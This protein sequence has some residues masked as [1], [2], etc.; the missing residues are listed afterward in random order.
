[1]NI[2]EVLRRQAADRG[3]APALID[4]HRGQDR[5][6]R[7][8]ELESATARF[9]GQLLECGIG[10][11][12]AVL[13]LHPMCA[14][15]YAF[16]IALFRVG[17]IGMFLDTSSGREYVERCLRI[18]PPKA[19]FGSAKAQLLRLWIP[20]LQAVK[21]KMCSR[22]FPGTM[23]F[24][25][26]SGA[27]ERPEL[28]I[29]GE[30][31][32][33]LITFTSGS[34]G[35]PKAAVRTHGFLLAQH[36][37]LQESLH[38]CAGEFDLT[39]LPVFVL[40]NLASGVTSV[41][42][43]ADMRRP[44]HIDP[45]PVLRQLQRHPIR[46]MAASPAFVTRLVG[47]CRRS[48]LRPDGLRRVFVGG[49]PVFPEDLRAASQT[50]PQAEITAIY[51]STEAEPMAE[52]ALSDVKLEDFAAMER[53]AG[54]LAGR[55]VN[56]ISLR[57]ICNQ[58]GTPIGELNGS[59]FKDLLVTT[60]QVGEIVVSG[61]HVLSGYL[62]GA[63]DAETKFRVDGVVWHR[64]GDLGRLD[65]CDRLWLLGR[66]SAA[67]KD[68]RGPLFPFAVEC[69]ARQVAGVRRAAILGVNGRRILVLEAEGVSV[70]AAR[71]AL[72][73]VGLDEV[74]LV[75]SIPIDKRH[76][77]KV[78][79]VELRRMMSQSGDNPL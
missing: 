62:N 15:L 69:A 68:E 51:G 56:S 77:A 67:I 48:G 16:L 1:M 10:G 54:L 8:R 27:V 4:V 63:G 20:S 7:F 70:E 12:D 44:G 39:T 23:C 64:T 38:H 22:W 35:E 37:A 6:L 42:P 79:Y 17:A 46:T 40:A 74:H 13:I 57:I 53:G 58:W 78:D 43:D 36:R 19:F 34:T 72:V 41:L 60:D 11:G 14:E 3:D 50:F 65:A 2:A 59:S 52:V 73:W 32:P 21:L 28:A 47:E 5:V 45:G 24:S 55:P 31:D 18:F 76:N 30:S 71:Q 25:L 9:S 61:K 33:A 49:A 75:R 66:A 26:N 29:T